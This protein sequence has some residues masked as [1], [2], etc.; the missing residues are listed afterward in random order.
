MEELALIIG[1]YGNHCVCVHTQTES[2]DS[3]VYKK[4]WHLCA[5]RN[6]IIGVKIIDQIRV[7][8]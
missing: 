6:Q 8:T 7:E 3:S 1:D 2:D 4:M 5:E